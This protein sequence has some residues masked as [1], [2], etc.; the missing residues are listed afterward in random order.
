MK[1]DGQ[2]M[3]EI[4]RAAHGLFRMSESDY[5]VEPF[6]LG[7]E[8]APDAAL[9]R[10]L[11]GAAEH[12]PVKTRP[13][14]EFFRP[15]AFVEEARGSFGLAPAGRVRELERALLGNLSDVKVYR[16]GE[17]NIAVYVL[18]KSPG[19]SWLGVSTRVVET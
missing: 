15:S 12:A 13:A 5:A 19:G 17:I 10:R 18:G 11:S 3:E 2:I 16:V 4:E 14:E 9:L 6:R 1:T 7:A 8:E